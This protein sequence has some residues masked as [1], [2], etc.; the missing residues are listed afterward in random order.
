[1]LKKGKTFDEVR[2]EFRWNIPDYYNIGADICD[3]WADKEPGRL[4]IIDVEPGKPTREYSFGDLKAISNRLANALSA[5]GIGRRAGEMGDRVGVM[6]PQRFETAV[7][8]VALAKL[9]CISIPLFTLFGPDALLHRL[10]NS[11]AR[12]IVT[13]A[14]GVERIKPLLPQLPALEL[15]ICVDG[16]IGPAKSFAAVCAAESEVFEPVST[17]ADDPAILIYT[18]G[19]TGN[20]KGA[21]HA[22]RVLLGHLPGV[23]MSHEFLPHDG[24]RFWTPADWAWIGGLLDVLMPALHHGIPVVACRFTKFTAEAAFDL[25]KT[26]QIRNAFLPPTALKMMKLLPKTQTPKVRLRSVASGGEPLG[27]ELIEWGRATLGVTINEFYGQTECNMVVSSC[28]ALE[29]P[30]PGK[31]GRSVPGHVVDVIDAATGIRQPNETEGALAVLSPDPVMFIGYW[32]NPEGT[33]EKFVEGPD[34]K[35]LLT[36]DQGVRDAEGRLHFVGRNDDVIGSAGYRIG[37][38]EVEDCLLAHQ[39]VRLAGVVAKPDPLRGAVVAAY[40]VLK[41]GHVGSDA[42]ADDIANFVKSR[43]AAHEYPRVVRFI[44]E[45]PL[46]TTG[47]IIRGALRKMAQDEAAAE[48]VAAHG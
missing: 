18:S 15:I 12:A 46:T 28:A 10:A 3:R 19:T 5:R 41:D 31:M 40:V 7:V 20:P 35:W 17:R 30:F 24:D 29:P 14:S 8:H 44:D 43:L 2:N 39:A 38:A 26:C 6:L 48:Q 25:I 34:G 47:K 45:I 9:A 21:L 37:P 13:D 42:L 1:M 36:G 23:E 33:R 32:Q 16:A 11:G 22:H 4:A 27:A